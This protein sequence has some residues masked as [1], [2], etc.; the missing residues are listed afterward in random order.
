[1]PQE[2]KAIRDNLE[3]AKEDQLSVFP[4]LKGKL[5]GRNVI[6]AI[7]GVGKSNAA[8]VASIFIFHFKPS[9][10]VFTGTGSRLN[11]KLRTGD[12]IIGE[13]TAHHDM[14]TVNSKGMQYRSFRGPLKGTITPYRYSADKRLLKLAKEAAKTYKPKEITAN[15]ETYYPIIKTGM[16]CGGDVFGQSEARIQAIRKELKAELMEME[17]P[18]ISLVCRQLK[19][20]H[21]VFRGG[22]NLTQE[23]PSDDYQRLGPVAAHSAANFTMHFIAHLEESEKR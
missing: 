14:G 11:P 6:V 19:V 13:K 4:Y 12:I 17:S 22:S 9:E 15:G 7:T 2:V 10:V 8:M 23:N 18:V 16:L 1:M 21:L 5:H 20:P 3:K